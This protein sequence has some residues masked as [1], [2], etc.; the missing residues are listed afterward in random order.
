M[1]F[2]NDLASAS[3]LDVSDDSWN[4]IWKIM[5]PNRIQ[6]FVLLF[7]HGKIMSNAERLRRRFTMLFVFE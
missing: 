3:D 7:R 4:V 6:M 1:K 2:A 5:V